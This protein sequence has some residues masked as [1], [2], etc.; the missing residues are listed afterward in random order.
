SGPPAKEVKMR[1]DVDLSK[2]KPVIAQVISEHLKMF[3]TDKDDH[4]LAEEFVNTDPVVGGNADALALLV[5]KAYRGPRVP[6]R[7]MDK[8]DENMGKKISLVRE[9]AD[10]IL[11]QIDFKGKL[12]SAAINLFQDG[13]VVIRILPNLVFQFLPRR[14]V[15]ALPSEYISM[16]DD[17][18]VSNWTDSLS[19]ARKKTNKG[20]LGESDISSDVYGGEKLITHVDYYIINEGSESEEV[21]PAADIIHIKY[22]GY[23]RMVE[24]SKGRWCFNVWSVPP[25]RRLKKTMLWKANAMINDILWRDAMPP[26]EHHKLDLSMFSPDL[27]DGESPEARVLAAQTAAMKV[28]TN[29]IKHISHKA[30][31]TGYVTDLTT[32]INVIE[33]R[34]QSYA[35]P[36]E[37][38][39]Q[40]DQNIHATS[41]VPRGAMYGEGSGAYASELL[42]SNYAGLRAEFIGDRIARPFEDWL[43]KYMKMNYPKTLSSKV[44]DRLRL[45]FRLILPRDVREIAQGV[46]LLM[47]SMIVDVSQILETVGLDTMS[48]EQ[49]EKHLE[50]IG[51]MSE[52]KGKEKDMFGGVEKK[53]HKNDASAVS[54]KQETPDTRASKEDSPDQP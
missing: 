21:I 46:N 48:G 32:E 36:N 33:A 42:V 3:E 6:S 20:I 14:I 39:M 37:L 30:V 10:D 1:A 35:D 40:L 7:L 24:D 47:Q 51:K 41:G 38:L 54:R 8:D 34:S 26:R 44:I 4:E 5:Q 45:K 53:S 49:F 23:G 43:K 25:M 17:K 27:Y 13:D 29:Y 12:S 2:N 18:L 50:L 11:Y 28:I 16:K 9:G 19:N 31:D 52:A 15:T 22:N